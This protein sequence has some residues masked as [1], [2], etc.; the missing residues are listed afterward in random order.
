MDK[1]DSKIKI[2]LNILDDL[3]HNSQL[4]G[5]ENESSISI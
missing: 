3:L 5:A 1:N 2:S 4:E